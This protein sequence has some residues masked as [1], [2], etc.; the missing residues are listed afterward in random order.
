M[1]LES[2]YYLLLERGE[3]NNLGYL[4]GIWEALGCLL[5]FMLSPCFEKYLRLHF[6][7]LLMSEVPIIYQDRD[8]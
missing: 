7:R 6:T 4:L 1:L 2:E 3:N 5:C 8:I